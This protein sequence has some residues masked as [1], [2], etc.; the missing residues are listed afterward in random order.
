[1]GFSRTSFP[2]NLDFLCGCVCFKASPLTLAFKRST[3]H[4]LISDPGVTKQSDAM[5]QNSGS[6][7]HT[8]PELPGSSTSFPGSLETHSWQR[9]NP[10]TLQFTALP[11]VPLGSGVAF[12]VIQAAS[13]LEPHVKV[14][15]M[16]LERISLLLEESWS[17]CRRI[18]HFLDCKL[19]CLNRPFPHLLHPHSFSVTSPELFCPSPHL[20]PVTLRS[21][22]PLQ[23]PHCIVFHAQPRCTSTRK[24]IRP[25]WHLTLFEELDLSLWKKYVSRVCNSQ[26]VMSGGCWTNQISSHRSTYFQ[27]VATWEKS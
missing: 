26:V 7:G 14:V 1:M 17:Y 22:P 4:H 27:C 19:L 11:G 2:L 24:V 6:G 13:D 8:P 10:Q 9:I 18:S 23:Q 20:D 16:R 5:R 15:P 12:H 3:P 21:L 25:G